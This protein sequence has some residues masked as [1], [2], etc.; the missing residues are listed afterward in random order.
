MQ[1]LVISTH[2]QGE[3]AEPSGEPPTTDPSATSVSLLVDGPLEVTDASYENHVVFTGPSTFTETGTV[4]Y[5]DGEI[6]V[7]TVGEG[8]LNPSPEGG[9]MQGAVVWRV[10][11][12]RGSLEGAQGLITSNFLLD[13]STGRVEDQQVAV[14][15]VP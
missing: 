2:F 3:A 11:A 5:D 7:D 9:I 8:T 14:L 6:D 10:T 15:F 1:R 4:R 13:P 12:A